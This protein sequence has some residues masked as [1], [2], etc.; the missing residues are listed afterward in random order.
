MRWCRGVHYHCVA[1]RCLVVVVVPV[2]APSPW[3]PVQQGTALM[4]RHSAVPRCWG[5]ETWLLWLWGKISRFRYEKARIQ[6][7]VNTMRSILAQCI[8]WGH[9]INQA[10]PAINQ[11]VERL[12]DNNNKSNPTS[13]SVLPHDSDTHMHI[14]G[15]ESGLPLLVTSTESHP[16]AEH[17]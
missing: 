14:Y 10:P 12:T 9:L 13:I 16:V 17:A 11:S 15:H 6:R 1:V 2:L 3:A 8:I 7:K 5:V 4:C